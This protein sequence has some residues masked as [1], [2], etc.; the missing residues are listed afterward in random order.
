MPQ[1][2]TMGR[3]KTNPRPRAED[4]ETALP[5][6][7]V[8]DPVTKENVKTEQPGCQGLGAPVEE[9]R[10]RPDSTRP[11]SPGAQED[12]EGAPL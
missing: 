4:P 5:K 11:Q 10:T 3:R 2:R 9:I 12:L 6:T 1:N 8:S 7:G